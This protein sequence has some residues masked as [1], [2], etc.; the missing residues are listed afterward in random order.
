MNELAA[1]YGMKIQKMEAVIEDLNNGKP[2]HENLKLV[3][4]INASCGLLSSR[5]EEIEKAHPEL[6]E[7]EPQESEGEEWISGFLLGDD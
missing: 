4:N 6:V 1:A 2:Y 3:N 5:I 7:N